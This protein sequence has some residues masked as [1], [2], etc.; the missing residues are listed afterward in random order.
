MGQTSYVAIFLSCENL[1]DQAFRCYISNASESEWVLRREGRISSATRRNQNS[2]QPESKWVSCLRHVDIQHRV[3]YT[4][5]A[6]KAWQ[7]Q[8]RQKPWHN[9]NHQPTK[10]QPNSQ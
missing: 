8:E 2:D 6:T 9:Q 3:C 7:R 10:P 1:H 5:K 4:E